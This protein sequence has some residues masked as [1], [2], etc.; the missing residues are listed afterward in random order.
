MV[1]AAG[2]P[3]MLD[4]GVA[5]ATTGR[6]YSTAGRRTRRA[7]RHRRASPSCK[8]ARSTA[9]RPLAG[10]QGV[11]HGSH[12]SRPRRPARRS[13]SSNIRV[14]PA[15]GSTS[16]SSTTTSAC[17]IES[18]TSRSVRSPSRLRPPISK[19]PSTVR[20][21]HRAEFASRVAGPLA[22]FV[23]VHVT[24]ELM[25]KG[26]QHVAELFEQRYRKG[27]LRSFAEC[28]LSG[29]QTGQ[30]PDQLRARTSNSCST[31]T[32]LLFLHGTMALAH[33]GF[34]QVHAPLLE[35]YRARMRGS[36]LGV[37]PSHAQQR[38]RARNADRPS[39][40]FCASWTAPR[41]V[42]DVVAR[43][44]AASSHSKLRRELQTQLS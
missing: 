18:S 6:S 8:S 12:A 17:A 5:V 41:L 20:R 26:T 3:V 34:E 30:K 39:S 19:S 44:V 32:S 21:R 14:P 1:G 37:R 35:R 4:S 33:T 31:S 40:A 38:R 36:D 2:P 16:C 11:Q 42:V 13:R 25:A 15:S 23:V 7:T 27:G 22:R 9:P 24:D 28:R 10:H 43:A 29:G